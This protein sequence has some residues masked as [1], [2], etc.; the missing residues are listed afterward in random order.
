M[1]EL[2]RVLLSNHKKFISSGKANNSNI[3]VEPIRWEVDLNFLIDEE[4]IFE[5]LNDMKTFGDYLKFSNYSSN[6]L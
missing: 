3:V 2:I 4:A 6:I 1:D 5:S